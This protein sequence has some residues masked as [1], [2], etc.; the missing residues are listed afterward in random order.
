M[1]RKLPFWFACLALVAIAATPAIAGEERAGEEKAA[2][3]KRELPPIASDEEA[4][5]A[6][7]AFKEHYKAKGLKGNEKIAQRDWAMEQL[8]QIQHKDVVDALAKALKSKDE[9]LKIA[10]V[11]HMGSQVALPGYAGKKVVEAMQRAKKNEKNFLMSGLES[12]G[13]LRYLGGQAVI[14]KALKHHDF[15]VKKAAIRAVGE[16][17]DMRLIDEML[18]QVDVEAYT[19]QDPKAAGPDKGKGGGS[20]GGGET[21]EGY[22]WEG[23]EAFV[24]RGEADNTQEN[25][26]AEREARA[27]A[28]ANRA[29]A[30]ARAAAEGNSGGG[31]GAPGGGG[32]GVGGAGGGGKGASGRSKQELI[33][34]IKATLKMLTGED[35]NGARSIQ[36]WVFD[37]K[38][39]IGSVIQIL[40]RDE[41]A[42]KK[43]AKK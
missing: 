41:K 40:D 29:E 28:E 12:L 24:D 35:F 18:A 4:A 25:A 36:I 33:Y 42:Q 2:E 22:S 17:M 5:E 19:K 37:N 31:G 3:A 23:A 27:Q 6:I 38:D 7:K 32:S 8:I 30:E 26:D 43:A 20:S 10:A 9:N 14:I 15:S 21:T 1:V 39:H 16:T 34:P 11:V 13:K